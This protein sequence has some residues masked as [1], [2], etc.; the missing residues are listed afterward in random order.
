MLI[1]QALAS[2]FGRAIELAFPPQGVVCTMRLPLSE[3]L[4]VRSDA[5]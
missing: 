1:E 5:A 3:R 4:M 2:E